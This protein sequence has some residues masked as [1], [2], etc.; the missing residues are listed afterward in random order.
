M[1]CKEEKHSAAAQRAKE[2]VLALS[3]VEEMCIVYKMLSEPTRL[4][5]M[6]ALMQGELC[7]Y[8]IA[9]ACDATV[10]AI[11]HQLRVLKDNR[12]VKAKRFGK[13]VEYSIVDD[14]VR[15]ILE[16]GIEHLHC[17]EV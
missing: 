2:H 5:I 3:E 12:I 11:S 6:L 4:R 7:V 16:I 8:H 10:S 13:N 9:E 14:H 17:A 1:I 15:K